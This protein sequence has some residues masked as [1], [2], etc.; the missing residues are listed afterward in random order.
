VQ[1]QALDWGC[2]VERAAQDPNSWC[3]PG[4]TMT[5]GRARAGA[6]VAD[7]TEAEPDDE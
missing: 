7:A 1:D 6:A 3:A 2:A 4:S 5:T